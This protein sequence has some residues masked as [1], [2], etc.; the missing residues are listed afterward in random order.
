[1]ACPMPGLLRCVG[2]LFPW[3]GR[4]WE[5]WNSKPGDRVARAFRWAV[6]AQQR[7]PLLETEMSSLFCCGI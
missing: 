6:E 2:V 4:G 5:R 7:K 3:R 1:M